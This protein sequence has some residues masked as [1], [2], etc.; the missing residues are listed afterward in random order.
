MLWIKN[1]DFY[2]SRHCEKWSHCVL[3]WGFLGFFFVFGVF[4]NISLKT[5]KP[6]ENT[7]KSLDLSW[8]G[9]AVGVNASFEQQ[10]EGEVLKQFGFSK[11]M[12]KYVCGFWFG[13]SDSTQRESQL[14][15]RQEAPRTYYLSCIFPL[16][17]HLHYSFFLAFYHLPSAPEFTLPAAKC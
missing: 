2:L 9:T 17:V 5:Q 3:G 4:F 8:S 7:K 14:Q 10:W 15:Y 12:S 11:I 6:N 16:G 13:P 1:W